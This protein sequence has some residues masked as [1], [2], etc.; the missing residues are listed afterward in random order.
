MLATLFV[1]LDRFKPVNDTLGHHVG[2]QLLVAVAERIR[3]ALR[4]ADTVAR[5]GGDEFVILIDGLEH[6]H[7]ATRLAQ[8]L[9]DTLAQP[10]VLH[11]QAIHMSASVGVSIYP[12]DGADSHTLLVHADQAMYRAK[13]CGGNQSQLYLARTCGASPTGF[14]TR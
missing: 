12:V 14:A 10:F 9:V 6:P 4:Q 3:V 2:D 8:K 11:G 7:I 5:I 13:S 1:D